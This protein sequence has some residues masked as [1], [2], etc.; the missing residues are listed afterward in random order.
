[1]RLRFSEEGETSV[2]GG[3]T[4]RDRKTISTTKNRTCTWIPERKGRRVEV[5]GL[6]LRDLPEASLASSCAKIMCLAPTI[7]QLLSLGRYISI[8]A[9]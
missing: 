1:M 5:T 3:K 8:N 7:Y 2:G 6:S 9:S 4:P